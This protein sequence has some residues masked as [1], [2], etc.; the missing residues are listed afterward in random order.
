[1]WGTIR[2]MNK[3]R[4]EGIEIKQ[5]ISDL[6]STCLLCDIISVI[7]EISNLIILKHLKDRKKKTF[8]TSLQVCTLNVVSYFM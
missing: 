1:M 3:V 2:K 6:H 7:K 4:E 8:N 5:V